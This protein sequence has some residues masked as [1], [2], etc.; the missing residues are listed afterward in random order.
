MSDS[1][2]LTK[3]IGFPAHRTGCLPDI[4]PVL[5]VYFSEEP[6][7]EKYLVTSLQVSNLKHRDARPQF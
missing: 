4:L 2:R 3:G 1:D 6:G 5:Y 7:Q